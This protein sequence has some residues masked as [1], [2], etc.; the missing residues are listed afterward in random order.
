MKYFWW[1][2]SFLTPVY[3]DQQNKI[4]RPQL[5]HSQPALLLK[6]FRTENELVYWTL[7]GSSVTKRFP[8]ERLLRNISRTICIF[9]QGWQILIPES[10]VWVSFLELRTLISKF[11]EPLLMSHK[12]RHLFEYRRVSW[13]IACSVTYLEL[14]GEEPLEV[15]I[16]SA[17]I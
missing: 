12:T 13:E 5:L 10:P 15:L 9:L 17:N 7:F 2:Y 8:S 14:F 3:K 16:S 6:S 1:N 4:L 11:I